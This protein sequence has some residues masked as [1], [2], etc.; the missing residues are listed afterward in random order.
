M[1]T[2]CES[3]MLPPPG[4]ITDDRGGDIGSIDLNSDLCRGPAL[5]VMVTPEMLVGAV[6][7]VVVRLDSTDQAVTAS[8]SWG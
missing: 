3:P 4:E 7:D 8:R 2:L 1:R 6:R 5:C